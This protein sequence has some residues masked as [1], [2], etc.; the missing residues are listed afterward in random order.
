MQFEELFPTINL[1][2]KLIEFKGIIDEGPGKNNSNKEISWLK[3]IVAFA[4]SMGGRLFIGVDNDSHKILSLNH[5]DA[6]KCILLIHRLI[7]ERITP[8]IDYDIIPHPIKGKDETR[9]LLEVIIPASKTRPV[10]LKQNGLLG[11]Y[12]RK[13][14]IAREATPEEI[15]ELALSSEGVAF[16]LKPTNVDFKFDDFTMLGSEFSKNRKG[17]SLTEKDIRSTHGID[18]KEKLLQGL[19]MFADQY[20]NEKTKVVATLWPGIDKGDTKILATKEFQGNI[21]SGIH[22]ACDFVA[23]HSIN[24]FEKTNDGRIDYYSYPS[25]SVLEGVVN[26]FVHRNYFFAGR[27]EINL[28]L[29]RLEIVSPGSL[30]GVSKKEKEKNISSIQSR[31]RNDLICRVLKLVRLMEERGSGFD[32]ITNEYR[33][34]GDKYAPYIESD[35]QSFTLTLPNLTYTQGLINEND[36]PDIYLESI[37]HNKNDLAILSYCF[38]KE[39]SITEIATKLGVKPSSYFRNGSIYRLRDNGYLIESEKDGTR[40]YLSNRKKVFLK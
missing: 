13:T 34:R 16:D 37:T 1:E 2:T 23:D 17:I 20:S 10:M 14:G 12:I 9:Y 7:P 24:G 40:V 38:N 30:P 19:Y 32:I 36:S 22:F 3:E 25:R 8:R 27:I 31:P 11:I 35:E 39:R 26:A 18:D 4:N 6:D 29:D 28:Y 21:L 33:G 15:I 5:R